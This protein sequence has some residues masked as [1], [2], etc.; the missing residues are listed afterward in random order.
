MLYLDDDDDSSESSDSS[1]SPS[2][3]N[4]EEQPT[5]TDEAQA[6]KPVNASLSHKCTTHHK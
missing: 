3:G 6:S 5:D 2:S 1:S 4:E